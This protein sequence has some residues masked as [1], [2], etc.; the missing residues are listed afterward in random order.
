MENYYETLNLQSTATLNE[1][2]AAFR[3]LVKE[4]HPDSSRA[5]GGDVAKFQEINEAYHNLV[6]QISGGRDEQRVSSPTAVRGQTW[7]FEGASEKGFDVTYTLRVSQE[8]ANKGLKINLPWNKEDACPRCL[9]FGHTL[10]PVFGG[11][12]LRKMVCP[13][14]KGAG[15][16][17]DESNLQLN[18]TP[19]IIG[20]GEI[21]L[22]GK[23]RYRPSQAARGDLVVKIKVA[24]ERAARMWTA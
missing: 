8:A 12:H 19:D 24:K 7:R 16:V 4:Y 22:Q 21:R 14:C 6:N 9:G 3:R 1:V 11:P 23:G 18:L 20:S 13:K 17:T 15:V 2:K 10:A 5:R